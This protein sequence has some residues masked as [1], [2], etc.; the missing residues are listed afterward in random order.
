MKRSVSPV[1]KKV[2]KPLGSRT[3]GLRGSARRRIPNPNAQA[4][5]KWYDRHQRILPWR[6]LRDITPDPYHV[7]LSE[8][9]L[10]QTTV[11]AVGPYYQR[12]LKRWP[13]LKD[14]AK[15][16]IDEVR[17]MWAGLGYYRR[18]Q[19]LHDC[20]ILV[21]AKY[22]GVFPQSEAELLELPGF[23]PYT[24]A[25][26]ASIAFDK[27]ANVVDGNVER[28]ISR[29]FAIQTPLPQAKAE[30]RKAAFSLL[31]TSRHGDYAQALM[32]LGATIC[33]PRNPKCDLCPWI[34]ACQAHALGVQ[35]ELP[36]K[37]KA[38]TRPIRRAI[39]FVLTNAEGKILLRRRSNPGLLG[40]MMEVPSTT[41]NE[42][43]MPDLSDMHRQAPVLAKWTLLPGK[44]KHVFSHFQFE[45]AVAT[46]SLKGKQMSRKLSGLWVAPAELKDHALPSVMIKI[47]RHAF[48]LV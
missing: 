34:K 29:L 18:A 27:R 17:Q 41:W 39:A 16:S 35:Q 23:G 6:A 13:T 22:D 10:Q 33:T 43:A 7:W 28:V 24:A 26:V 8:I 21:C 3:Q 4:L 15:A 2:K 5:L 47:V 45:V 46:A 14:L 19:S 12:F 20:A 11:A 42:G 31:P 9:M 36:R 32:D 30:I 1:R 44:V 38:K 37:I 40:G 25:A 48:G